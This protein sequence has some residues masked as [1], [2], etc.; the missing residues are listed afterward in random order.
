MNR[1]QLRQK[2][3]VTVDT[4]N[5]AKTGC[6]MPAALAVLDKPCHSQSSKCSDGG[7][8]KLTLR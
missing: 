2:T 4:V 8:P 1:I 5:T 6:P 7:V 3:Q